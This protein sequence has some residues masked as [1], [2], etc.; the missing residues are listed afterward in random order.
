MI[1][2]IDL[3][4]K[5]LSRE[6]I[7]AAIYSIK[8]YIREINL[9]SEVDVETY[10]KLLDPFNHI[11]IK[12]QI[13][14]CQKRLKKLYKRSDNLFTTEVYFKLKGYDDE[15]KNFTYRPTH[16]CDLT[17]QICLVSMLQPLMFLDSEG[18]KPSEISKL[19]PEN[20]YGNIPSLDIEHL[21]QKWQ[22]NYK[23]YTDDIIEHSKLY[24]Q[25]STYLYEIGLDLKDFFPSVNPALVINRIVAHFSDQFTDKELFEETLTKLLYFNISPQ[26]ISGWE[27][28][29]YP[30][31]SQNTPSDIYLT[32]G[33]PQGLP[34]APFFGT[35]VMSVIANHL[36]EIF[37]EHDAYYYVDDSVIF[38]NI[39]KQQYDDFLE[40]Q[41][42]FLTE[43]DKDSKSA[44]S[45][46]SKKPLP[47]FLSNKQLAFL[48]KIDYHIEYHKDKKSYHRHIS[49]S[50]L[51]TG[52]LSFLRRQVSMTA[53]LNTNIDEYEDAS[54]LNK[55]Q[56]I[57]QV[58]KNEL[59]LAKQQLKE[60]DNER[61]SHSTKDGRI[62]LLQRHLRFFL[63]RERV[64]LVRDQGK[65]GLV[66]YSLKQ[67]QE[68]L[69]PNDLSD[70]EKK[71][72][73]AEGLNEEIFQASYKLIGNHLHKNGLTSFIKKIN[74]FEKQIQ[75]P[76]ANSNY[77]YYSKDS[78]ALT[79][80]SIPTNHA[81]E[82]LTQLLK[83]QF[84]ATLFSCEEVKQKTAL[85]FIHLIKDNHLK[86][87]SHIIPS[88]AL[89][90]AKYSRQFKRKLYN[91]FFS[92]IFNVDPSNTL[93]ITKNI[94]RLMSYD[95]LRILSY[96]RNHLCDVREFE[97][98]AISVLN[99]DESNVKS[100]SVDMALVSI[101]ETFVRY[102]GNA[103]HVDELILTHRKI[104]SLWKN[105]SK[106]LNDYTLHN[107]DHAICLI[108]QCVHI[109]HTID[110]LNIK[111]NDYYI[112]FLSCY[113]H[114]I[115]MVLHP[116]V[117]DFCIS[118]IETNSIVTKIN[119]L[120]S[121]NRH[122]TNTDHHIILESFKEVYRYFEEKIRKN[123]AQDSANYILH[124]E[125]Y[126]FDFIP[127]PA[128]HLVADVSKSHYA[129]ADG[130]Y[131]EKSHA[132]DELFS[133]K[134]MKILIRLADLLDMCSD[135]ISFYRMQDMLSSMNSTSRF[136]W[137][138]HL[139]TESARL[140]SIYK[141]N[142]N[143]DT[144][145]VSEIGWR[146]WIDEVIQINI[147]LNSAYMGNVTNNQICKVCYLKAPFSQTIEKE[148]NH[149]KEQDPC[150]LCIVPGNTP[151]L[152]QTS[153]PLTCLWFMEKN[154]WLINELKHLETY[155]NA[156]NDRLFKTRFEINY[157]YT[158]GTT[159]PPNM[160]DYITDYIHELNSYNAGLNDNFS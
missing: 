132:K 117:D 76:N 69:L 144:R 84:R 8:S 36:K 11:A 122:L 127:K 44:T 156:A 98:F 85:K 131:A 58:I 100:I 64:L 45:N 149:S 97:H 55:I 108:R 118:S 137:I 50:H 133:L 142:N 20:F 82:S 120:K 46:S 126:N 72:E 80:P 73:Y 90:V 129:D 150:V 19:F 75:P 128:L 113:M 21:Y 40:N 99:S 143:S 110:Y 56:T 123:H 147:N 17:T 27:K 114:D 145:D 94:N 105:G 151:N 83:R 95:E 74:T 139:T 34:Q 30:N 39:D 9:L 124:N 43:Y 23:K 59:K 70:T 78:K 65:G 38:A 87:F 14:E 47:R 16:V 106:F 68:S 2:K 6:N 31:I 148:N 134:Y 159:L 130:I 92:I 29:Y 35:L 77:L 157:H 71:R 89:F 103:Q 88:Y 49:K 116:R 18:R 63:I 115:S 152:A 24:A 160:I 51:F 109:C 158:P 7:Y 62:K 4:K 52:N 33:I 1:N 37:G 5:I 61:A 154:R 12:R 25:N 104:S 57:I 111:Q 3:R 26:N 86:I 54:T 155:L 32:R 153:C 13:E 141:L 66:D 93:A 107:E 102:V 140:E 138:S 146:H 135:R 81:Y 53:A 60:E 91:T 42:L 112:L 22:P 67:F 48:K 79:R 125:G 15:T 28:V 101:I 96:V 136:H 119:N 10:H 41:P 121:E